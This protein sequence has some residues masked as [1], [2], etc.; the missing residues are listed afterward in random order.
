MT[1]RVL[2]IIQQETKRENLLCLPCERLNLDFERFTEYRDSEEHPAEAQFEIP[3][4]VNGQKP[5]QEIPEAVPTILHYFLDGSRRTYKVA[6]LI[7]DGKRYLPLIA[8]QVGVAIVE[9]TADGHQVRPVRD[10]CC[11]R[12]IVVFPDLISQEDLDALESRINQQNTMHFC[13]LRYSLKLG[14]DPVDLGIARIMSEM[15]DLEIQ[16]VQQ[17]AERRLLDNDRL[18]VIDGPL[19]FKKKLDMVQFRN[20]IG[21][22]KSFRPSFTI[23]KGKRRTEVGQITSRLQ[24]K[25]RTSVYKTTEEEKIIGM[26]YLRLRRPNMMSNPLQG[27]IKLECYAITPEEQENGLEAERVDTISAHILRERSV[28]PYGRDWRWA[29]HIYPIYLAETYLK[30]SFMSDLHFQALF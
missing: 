21:L 26:W 14:H 7:V 10:F 24:F 1:Q 16:V 6:D 30:S 29:N 18:L 8:G 13:L 2:S 25:E 20:V 22:S 28:T 19:R 12:N 17:L 5:I 9:R 4:L 15:H 3:E 23:G 27:V 11:F